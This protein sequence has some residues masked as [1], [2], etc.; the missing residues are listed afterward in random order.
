MKRLTLLRHAKSSWKEP[1][2]TDR[3]RPLN[4]RGKR[5]A[6]EMGRRLAEGRFL[7]D[8][9]LSSPAKRARKTA[10]LVAEE[11]GFPSG[12]IIIEEGIYEADVGDLLEIVRSLDE[13]LSRVLLVGHNPGFTEF[14]NYLTGEGIANVPTCGVV[15]VDCPVRYWRELRRGKGRM[16]LFDFPKRIP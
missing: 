15:S 13:T 5:D 8:A 10:R 2:E 3:D 9:V 14:A 12:E 7:T 11:I 6:P 1:C 16:V 4:E